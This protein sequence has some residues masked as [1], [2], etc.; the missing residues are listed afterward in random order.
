MNRRRTHWRVIYISGYVL[1]GFAALLIVWD[2]STRENRHVVDFG[3]VVAYG[4][5][6]FIGLLATLIGES[7][8]VLEERLDQMESRGQSDRPG[9]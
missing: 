8:R 7:F 5:V 1:L 9:P 6:I 3:L 2:Y 4:A